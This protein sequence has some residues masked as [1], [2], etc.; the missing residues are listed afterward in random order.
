MQNELLNA[1]YEVADVQDRLMIEPLGDGAWR[2]RAEDMSWLIVTESRG[3]L[4]HP[5]YPHAFL[6]RP[7][8]NLATILFETAALAV[9]G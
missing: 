4:I 1:I 2:V 3:L 5:M 8:L 6:Y 7:R 9:G